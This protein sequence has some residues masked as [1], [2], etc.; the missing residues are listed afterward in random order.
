MTI[1]IIIMIFSHSL[2]IF[3]H[4]LTDSLMI[5][6]A[7]IG[8]MVGM[9]LMMVNGIFEFGAVCARKGGGRRESWKKKQKKDENLTIFS[10]KI[11]T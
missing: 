6:L 4:S 11:A 5:R 10:W 3:T 7:M 9:V 2:L 8:M 1:I